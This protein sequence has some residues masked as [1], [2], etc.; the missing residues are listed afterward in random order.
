MATRKATN[1]LY[2]IP[3]LSKALDIL[4]LLQ[5]ENKP[6]TLQ[7][8]HHQTRISKT[9]VYRVLKTFVHRR[10]LSQSPN[11]LYR[12]ETHPKK[13]Q[14]GFAAQNANTPFS[15]EVT[16]SLKNAAAK[17]GVDLL[18]L[19]NH[20]D[21]ATAVKNAEV[22]IRRKVDLVIEFQV[23][24]T[25]GPVIGDKVASAKI[26][27]IAVD[28]PHPN[29]TYFGVDNYRIGV[30]AGEALA[31][32]AS[33]HWGRKV[34]WVVGLDL[35][36]AGKLVQ[37]G[38]TGAFAGLQSRRPGLPLESFVRI[39]GHGMRDRSRKL[40]S[41][42]LQSH[43]N[44]HHILITAVTD[45]SVLGAVDAVEDHK[46]EKHVAIVGQDCISDAIAEMRKDKSPLIGLV[47]RDVSSYGPRLINL[48]MSLLHGQTVPPYNYAACRFVTRESL[49][50]MR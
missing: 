36:Q 30:E 19:D 26:P 48:G 44:D 38:I 39:D 12:H 45:S 17:V 18:I 34:D 32:Y 25:I 49:E 22:F 9:T 15:I 24:Q 21:A 20:C 2:L 33:E 16:E 7:V 27:L 11:G 28:I 40:V 37:S 41:D 14:F 1:R 42:F 29:A 10:Y 8:V 23:E 6:V 46:R 3:V 31:T 13:M 43:L 50:Q 35:S 47:S 4:E 5:R